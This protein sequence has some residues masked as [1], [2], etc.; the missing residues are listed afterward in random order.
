MVMDLIG[1]EGSSTH[2]LT[3]VR[4]SLERVA[5]WCGVVIAVLSLRIDAWLSVKMTSSFTGG[6]KGWSQNKSCVYWMALVMALVSRSV[7]A[8]SESSSV[9]ASMSNVPSAPMRIKPMPAF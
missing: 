9:L 4:R 1:F 5:L 8:Q 2:L 3:V 6:C 7:M